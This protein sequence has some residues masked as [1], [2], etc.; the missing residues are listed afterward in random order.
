ME[1]SER[2]MAHANLPLY[3]N[4]SGVYVFDAWVQE[5]RTTPLHSTSPSTPTSPKKKEE[6]GEEEKKKKKKTVAIRTESEGSDTSGSEATRTEN[7]DDHEY[8]GKWKKVVKGRNSRL[9][10]VEDDQIRPF[11]RL[12]PNWP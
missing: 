12:V 8:A 7:H 1:A 2:D 9:T 10:A 11:G 6:E 3:R 4:A 5:P